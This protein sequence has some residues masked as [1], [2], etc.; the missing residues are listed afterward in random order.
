MSP[1][2]TLQHT[3]C[4][5]CLALLA[6]FMTQADGLQCYAC[7]IQGQSSVD[8]GCSSPEVI[9]CSHFYKGFKQHYCIRTESTALKMVLT[10]GCATSR[11]CHTEELPG[12]KIHCCDSDLCNFASHHHITSSP[13]HTLCF[14]TA[15]LASFWLQL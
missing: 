8:V 6:F 12:V 7:N 4:F 10:S 11:H 5:C 1:C 2:P 3:I 15:T 14:L 9:T 13:S